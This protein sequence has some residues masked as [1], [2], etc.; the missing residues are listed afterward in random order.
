MPLNPPN[1]SIDDIPDLSDGPGLFAGVD[2]DTLD[3]SLMDVV[4]A[5]IDTP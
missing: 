5:I 3:I 1:L 2:G 4:I